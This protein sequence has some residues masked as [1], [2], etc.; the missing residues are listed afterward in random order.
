MHFCFTVTLK[1]ARRG[2]IFPEPLPAPVSK[3]AF[4]P[5][6]QPESKKELFSIQAH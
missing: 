6:D 5:Q 4:P 1:K 2:R 3:T